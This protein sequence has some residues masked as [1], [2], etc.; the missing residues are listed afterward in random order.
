MKYKICT[1]LDCGKKHKGL[2]LCSSHWQM[3]KKHGDP[4]A[5]TRK[6]NGEGTIS[7]HGYKR[8]HFKK[9]ETQ[10]EHRIIMEK[11]IGRKLLPNETVHH[12]NG[13]KLDNR[14]E[15]LELWCSRHPKGQRVE[16]LIAYA[17]EILEKYEPKAL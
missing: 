12:I 16:D 7:D 5:L 9:G 14:I 2:G 4:L 1:I 17:H 15:N 6:R 10:L 13:N 8:F 3:F 11:H